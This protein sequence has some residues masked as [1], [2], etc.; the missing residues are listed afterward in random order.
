MTRI[1]LILLAF[2]FLSA[3]PSPLLR[4][5]ENQGRVIQ[6]PIAVATSISAAK[7]QQ[8]RTRLRNMTP[9]QLQQLIEKIDKANPGYRQLL[10][11]E[12]Q[13]IRNEE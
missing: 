5:A 12:I 2:S 8:L 4:A 6:N 11:D 9:E 3:K 1:F 13:R 7:R 10:Q